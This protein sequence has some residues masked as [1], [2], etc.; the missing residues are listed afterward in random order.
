[1]KT[2][3]VVKQIKGKKQTGAT[4]IEYAVI[5]AVIVGA[6]IVVFGVL[7]TG[8]VDAF[9]EIVADINAAN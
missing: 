4:M 5:A 9:N 1:M 6:V 8:L 2:L 7:E 3:N